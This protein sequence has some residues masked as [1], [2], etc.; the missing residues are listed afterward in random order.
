MK[1]LKKISRQQPVFGF[2][3]QN[4]LEPSHESF[5]QTG[6]DFLE[7][8]KMQIDTGS[9]LNAYDAEFGRTTLNQHLNLTNT[10]AQKHSPESFYKSGWS[11]VYEQ[12]FGKQE[13]GK[14]LRQPE[15][16]LHQ[17]SLF[18]TQARQ[19]A[20]D[21]QFQ[22]AKEALDIRQRDNELLYLGTKEQKALQSIIEK[23]LSKEAGGFLTV[24]EWIK[25]G[26]TTKD[27]R[28]QRRNE[29]L[30]QAITKELNL[31]EQKSAAIVDSITKHMTSHADEIQQIETTAATQSGMNIESFRKTNRGKKLLAELIHFVTVGGFVGAGIATGALAP[32]AALSA[33][34]LVGINFKGRVP[35]GLDGNAIAQNLRPGQSLTQTIETTARELD[36]TLHMTQNL[37]NSSDILARG[38][39]VR[40][41]RGVDQRYANLRQVIDHQQMQFDMTS[42]GDQSLEN[43]TMYETLGFVIDSQGQIQLAEAKK[44]RKMLYGVGE[45]IFGD[46]HDNREFKKSKRILAD[47]LPAGAD[48][49]DIIAL[50]Q[51]KVLE[52]DSMVTLAE[53]EIAEDALRGKYRRHPEKLEGKKS[54]L[55]QLKRF[56]KTQRYFVN[57]QKTFY[58]LKELGNKPSHSMESRKEAL[59]EAAVI[60]FL[61]SFDSADQV[62]S[63]FGSQISI[64]HMDGRN[65]TPDQTQIRTMLNQYYRSSNPK[66][67]LASMICNTDFE[68]WMMSV[69]KFSGLYGE[70]KQLPSMEGLACE[71]RAVDQ[72]RKCDYKD[73]K[74]DSDFVVSP[75]GTKLYLPVGIPVNVIGGTTVTTGTTAIKNSMGSVEAGVQLPQ[76]V[77]DAMAAAANTPPK[78]FMADFWA[79]TM[80]PATQAPNMVGTSL[81]ADFSMLPRHNH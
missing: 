70:H 22:V 45:R 26:F 30:A 57:D 53:S 18:C 20:I 63:R 2:V 23:Q 46:H 65:F 81:G 52:L 68:T 36:N 6:L 50:N 60:S 56:A 80:L 54:M 29:K 59:Y 55:R 35:M 61:G 11:Q 41:L 1:T 42:L 9:A 10:L 39:N 44:F 62:I 69:G 48:L 19:N 72:R 28:N 71:C 38:R 31:P 43:K 79:P 16:V 15:E 14:F 67:V 78:P 49:T 51:K 7:R 40:Y 66:A 73:Y 37:I 12:K 33:L 8:I 3:Q 5:P 47:T 27:G 74:F 75:K 34:P 21:T 4:S 76:A 32:I 17:E 64:R 58:L 77:L 25:T 24:A 13:T